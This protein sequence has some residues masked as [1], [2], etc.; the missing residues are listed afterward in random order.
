MDDFE[1]GDY[2]AKQLWRAPTELGGSTVAFTSLATN[3]LAD[4]RVRMAAK[5]ITNDFTDPKMFHTTSSL[6]DSG[7]VKFNVYMS[8][9]SFGTIQLCNNSTCGTSLLVKLASFGNNQSQV[10][11]TVDSERCTCAGGFPQTQF[12]SFAHNNNHRVSVTKNSSGQVKVYVGGIL[13]VT[14]TSSTLTDVLTHVHAGLCGGNTA[15]VPQPTNAGKA[16]VE[17]DNFTTNLTSGVW[18]SEKINAGSALTRWLRLEAT[19]AEQGGSIL[20]TSKSSATNA[21]LDSVF[22]STITVGSQISTVA[23]NTFVQFKATITIS[24]DFHV[25]AFDDPQ[26]QLIRISWVEGGEAA[27]S[28]AAINWDGRYL[29]AVATAGTTLKSKMFYYTRS[30]LTAWSRFD[31]LNITGFQRYG[32]NFYGISSTT[33]TLVRLFTGSTDEGASIDAFWQSRDETLG[34]FSRKARYKEAFVDYSKDTGSS[35]TFGISTNSGA[36]FIDR[37][38]NFSGSG[39]GV[40]RVAHS[41]M[42][43][44]DTMRFRIRD[45]STNAQLKFY[46]MD[47]Y[48]EQ[49]PRTIR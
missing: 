17:F 10:C 23:A 9:P 34:E 21:G 7:E 31:G 24:N 27:A 20:F 30:P 47:V 15:Q 2:T 42:P 40:T 8:S 41:T 14:Y 43:L 44:G 6:T 38:I 35:F 39:R 16:Y 45:N 4:S 19:T 32:G 12:A 33:N 28:P 49:M 11:G 25:A 5:D 22:F 26:I 18:T 37:T 48:L 1:D 13:E 36:S 29:I 3:G 46:G